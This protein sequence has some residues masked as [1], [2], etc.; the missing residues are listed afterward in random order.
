MKPYRICKK[1]KNYNYNLE[2]LKCDNC[3]Y[4][5]TR[6][7][8]QETEL[9]PKLSLKIKNEPIDIMYGFLKISKEIYLTQK[10]KFEKCFSDT[11]IDVYDDK[12]SYY[13]DVDLLSEEKREQLLSICQHNQ[14]KYYIGRAGIGRQFFEN[15][16]HVS[17]IHAEFIRDNI[18]WCIMDHSKNGTY[19]ND[20]KIPP[21]KKH[22][23]EPGNIIRLSNF[24]AGK[25]IIFV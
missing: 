16:N 22:P 24:S 15:N 20:K 17:T 9:K 6:A 7:K 18:K 10:D 21:K 8:I 1:C 23:I 12:K 4:N 25:D 14:P 19:V 3:G 13:I 2:S 5:I 11:D